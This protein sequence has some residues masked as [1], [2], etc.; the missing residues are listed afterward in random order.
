MLYSPFFV[1]IRHIP[2]FIYYLII[3]VASHFSQIYNEF[4]EFVLV[5]N[6]FLYCRLLGLNS[7]YFLMIHFL[8]NSFM[9]VGLCSFNK[10]FDEVKQEVEP[11]N[12]NLFEVD[13]ELIDTGILEFFLH[14]KHLIN[15]LA[16]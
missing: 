12:I 15:T 7:L 8:L 9:E 14:K 16:G 3:D 11:I 1:S 10:I 6:K 4:Y 2:S 13:S 5:L